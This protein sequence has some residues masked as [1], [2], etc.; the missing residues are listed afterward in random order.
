MT[1]IHSGLW[2]LFSEQNLFDSNFP[3]ADVSVT[4][5]VD[6]LQALKEDSW[7]GAEDVPPQEW[8]MGI[9]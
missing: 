8:N 7:E 6:P 9:Q 1:K 5:S 4:C 2:L 3:G